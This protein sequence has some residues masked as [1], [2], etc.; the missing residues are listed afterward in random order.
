VRALAAEA[1]RQARLLAAA[2]RAELGTVEVRE[3]ELADAEEE[4]AR[5]ELR[6]FQARLQLL[7]LRGDL[8]AAL[9]TSSAGAAASAGTPGR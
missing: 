3:V 4:A 1:A 9:L 8:E 6:L 5:A 7:A 2:A